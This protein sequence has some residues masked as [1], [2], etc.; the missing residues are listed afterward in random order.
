LRFYKPDNPQKKLLLSVKC[1]L[2][3]WGHIISILVVGQEEPDKPRLFF[4]LANL[5]VAAT[6]EWRFTGVKRGNMGMGWNR[7]CEMATE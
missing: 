4:R 3:S 5:L 7:I 6:K 1:I 2:N